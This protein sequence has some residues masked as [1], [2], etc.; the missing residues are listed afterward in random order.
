MLMSEHTIAGVLQANSK[1][2]Q[3][4]TKLYRLFCHEATRV[5]GDRLI[6]KEDQTHFFNVLADVA[7]KQFGQVCAMLCFT[8]SFRA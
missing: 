4:S 8:R 2:I 3:D 7:K 6:N 5:F 1:V